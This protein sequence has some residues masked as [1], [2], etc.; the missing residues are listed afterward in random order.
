[1]V[2]PPKGSVS[3]TLP[4]LWRYV[5]QFTRHR[6]FSGYPRVAAREALYVIRAAPWGPLV[7]ADWCKVALIF[8]EMAEFVSELASSMCRHLPEG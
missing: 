4:D 2:R 8:V 1:M 6:D 3:T 7:D 5:S